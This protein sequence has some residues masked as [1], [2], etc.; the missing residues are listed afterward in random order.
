MSLDKSKSAEETVPASRSPRRIRLPSPG[1]TAVIVL[2]AVVLGLVTAVWWPYHCEQRIVAQLQGPLGVKVDAVPVYVGPEVLH[3]YAQR[4]WMKW[5]HRVGE[6]RFEDPHLSP[7]QLKYFP[8][9]DL[10]RHCR[11]VS[12]T[13]MRLEDASYTAP[14]VRCRELKSISI[15]HCELAGDALRGL[16]GHAG[17]GEI[18]ITWC[19][20]K[21]V[22]L[23]MPAATRL[24]AIR[25]NDATIDGFDV[26][27]TPNLR[28]LEAKNCRMGDDGV[29][30]LAGAPRIEVLM[31]PNHYG[32]LT[33][34]CVDHLLQLPELRYLDLRFQGRLTRPALER[35]AAL[36]KLKTVNVHRTAADEE[37]DLLQQSLPQAKSTYD[38]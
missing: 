10:L 17:L 21:P 5:F 30:M 8:D 15:H 23:E 19:H 22:I 4:P 26:S 1:W 24:W 11:T 2:T 36:P 20:W 38:P 28:R 14:F 18:T 35:L 33:D 32:P 34:E 12:F 27:R 37:F 3:T 7:Q 13:N 25:V 16:D 31:I 29:A 9:L 6:L